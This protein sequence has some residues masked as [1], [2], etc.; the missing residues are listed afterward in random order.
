MTDEHALQ[1]NTVHPSEEERPKTPPSVETL[2]ID[3]KT[4]EVKEKQPFPPDKI[5]L[6]V[7]VLLPEQETLPFLEPLLDAAPSFVN[8]KVCRYDPA[9]SNLF[10]ETLHTFKQLSSFTGPVVLLGGKVITTVT[11]EQFHRLCL[12]FHTSFEDY[13]V[14]YLSWWQDRCDWHT[15]VLENVSGFTLSLSQKAQNDR[16]FLFSKTGRDKVMANPLVEEI[17]R[18]KRPEGSLCRFHATESSKGKLPIKE[19]SHFLAR[20]LASAAGFNDRLF[21][22]TQ[23]KVNLVKEKIERSLRSSM[24]K[25][26]FLS[27]ETAL[28]ERRLL[29]PNDTT[30]YTSPLLAFMSHLHVEKDI[31]VVVVSPPLFFFNP[32]AC[33]AFE[34]FSTTQLCTLP[35]MKKMVP[36]ETDPSTT[37]VWVILLVIALFLILLG[38]LIFIIVKLSKQ[39]KAQAKAYQEVKTT[40]VVLT[41]SPDPLP[42]TT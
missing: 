20:T 40:S 1:D 22:F 2:Q 33:V 15:V 21:Q 23:Q 36:D 42:S 11:P 38:L 3:E 31:N 8:V 24:D 14:L 18:E 39:E 27:P 5:D 9:R 7:C 17:L 28:E 12:E 13:D 16:A 41:P 6:I 10:V 19:P 32:E 4:E 25:S 26:F 37:Y 30:T 34:D 35:D 29:T